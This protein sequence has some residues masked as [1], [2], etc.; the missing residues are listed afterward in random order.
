MSDSLFEL[1][2][3]LEKFL[4]DDDDYNVHIQVGEEPDKKIFKAHS[5]ILRARCPYFRAA[6]SKNWAKKDDNYTTFKKPNISPSVFEAILKYIYT[7]VVNVN[8]NDSEVNVLHLLVAADELMLVNYVYKI[9]DY[10]LENEIDWLQKNIIHILNITFR[11]DSCSKIREYCLHETCVEPNLVFGSKDFNSLD[12]EVFI[13]LLKRG[14]LWLEEIEIWDIIIKWGTAQISDQIEEKHITDW[15]YGDFEL[16]KNKISNL[17]NLVGFTGISSKDFYYKVWPYKGILPIELS[18]EIVRF[19]LDPDLQSSKLSPMAR[20]PAL[21]LDSKII[22]AKHLAMISHWIDKKT[23]NPGTNIDKEFKLIFRGTR[24][25]FTPSS[26]H[27]KCD[28]KGSCVVILKV[29]ENGNILGGYN[30]LG[31]KGKDIWGYT[32][33]SFLFSLGDGTTTKNVILSRVRSNFAN[34]AIFHGKMY[35]PVFGSSD[36]EMKEPYNKQQNWSAQAH[37]YEKRIIDIQGFSVDEYEV[38]QVIRK[39]ENEN[40]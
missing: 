26:F 10:L 20:F 14:D 39:E 21:N 16:L 38:F 6:F 19:H 2:R 23:G 30:P 28:N 7:G 29:K 24:D 12:E 13:H 31:W 3:D 8:P 34:S 32:E 18:D 36:L 9:Q 27:K 40:T 11:Q 1:S 17:L 33:D 15:S 5:A 22:N 37:T 4:Q 25:G 35:G